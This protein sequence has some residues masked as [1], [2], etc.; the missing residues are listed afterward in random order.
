MFRGFIIV[1]LIALLAACGF[2]L[3][4]SNDWPEHL[5]A[6]V[7]SG[8]SSTSDLYRELAYGLDLRGAKVVTDAVQATSIIRIQAFDQSREELTTTANGT[9]REYELNTRL[10]M[11]L[12]R[13][14]DG[15]VSQPIDLNAYQ[16]LFNDTN[17]VLSNEQQQRFIREEMRTEVVNQ[18]LLRLPALELVEPVRP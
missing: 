12:E 11:Q 5:Q 17:N 15:A 13:L 9:V 2:Q 16:A 6:V 4:G 18:L 7:I 8:V 3:R 1:L 10:S 14:V